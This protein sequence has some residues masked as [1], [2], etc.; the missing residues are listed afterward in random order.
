MYIR[1]VVVG[2][3]P[4]ILGSC[5]DSGGGGRGPVRVL[6]GAEAMQASAQVAVSLG[7]AIV[8]LV[9]DSGVS[10]DGLSSLAEES[11][12]P[13]VSRRAIRV[14]CPQGG[15]VD[16][17]CRAESG[18][19]IVTTSSHRCAVV[20]SGVLATASGRLTATYERGGLCGTSSIPRDIPYTFEFEDFREELRLDGDLVRSFSAS[21]LTETVRP[22][23]GGCST[24]DG[25][26][27]L[28]GDARV[29]EMG[30]DMTLRMDGLRLD[31]AS[32]GNPCA[33]EAVATGVVDV[34]DR[35][36]GSR[37]VAS[38]DQLR[39]SPSPPHRRVRGG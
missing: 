31:V 12:T 18:R 9:G 20:E 34:E 16:G 35:G 3:I 33:V 22:R 38:L 1:V 36:R 14:D 37:F 15:S 23:V 21:R 4:F 19:T 39:V 11:S 5:S 27:S 7:T 30:S 8:A 2:L 17:D 6:E 10:P 28:R 32:S 29:I 26:L 25:V 24:A 13:N